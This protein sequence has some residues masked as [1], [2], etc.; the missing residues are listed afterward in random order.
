MR[1]SVALLVASFPLAAL[2]APRPAGANQITVKAGESIQRAV[3]KAAPGDQLL[4]FGEHAEQVIIRKDLTL[5]GAPGAKIMFPEIPNEEVKRISVL[6]NPEEGFYIDFAPVVAVV[7]ANVT[8]DGFEIDGR[9][10]PGT[11]PS[12][13]GVLFHQA[14]GAL[15]RSDVHGIAGPGF[16]VLVPGF[17]GHG[18]VVVNEAEGVRHVT[19]QGCRIHE[20]AYGGIVAFGLSDDESSRTVRVR[21]LIEDNVVTGA[22]PTRVSE[23]FGILV[24]RGAVGE[25]RRNLVRDL[26]LVDG[27]G[28][29][30]GTGI[31][32][33]FGD[34]YI[35]EDNTLV[36][37]QDGIVVGDVARTIIRRNHIEQAPPY[38]SGYPT[39]VYSWADPG[40]RSDEAEISDNVVRSINNAGEFNTS[41]GI[42]S[43]GGNMRVTGN[44]VTLAGNEPQGFSDGYPW[45]IAVFD[46]DNTVKGNLVRSEV[47][48]PDIG[49][50]LLVLAWFG[51]GDE[52]TGNRIEGPGSSAGQVFGF[53]A[54]D[55]GGISVH[56]N[57]FVGVRTGM[58]LE[59]AF[60]GHITPNSYEDVAWR[61]QPVESLQNRDGRARVNRFRVDPRR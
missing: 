31:F 1:T 6:D 39:C 46:G 33:R 52:I 56:D 57:D 3:D 48:G 2:A 54:L 49:A 14:D 55:V 21:M 12:F 43:F 29:H 4:V 44:Q 59:G 37:V 45:G 47:Q 24:F 10:L 34:E 15:L 23:Q 51:Q 5:V 26:V 8:I 27:P 42:L 9:M 40:Q 16:P 41:N 17:E 36:N 13:A 35:V 7:R 22:G 61:L 19:I 58:L 30:P 53:H 50:P 18:V 38:H 60:S 28:G 32:G 25:V 11:V 20:F